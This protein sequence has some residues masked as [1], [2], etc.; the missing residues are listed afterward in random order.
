MSRPCTNCSSSLVELVA[1]SV[2]V[3]GRVVAMVV[4][5]AVAMVVATA[6]VSAVWTVA[7]CWEAVGWV[8]AGRVVA[9]VV[10]T[11][12]AMVVGTGADARVVAGLVVD[13]LV[14]EEKAAA[15]VA[16]LATAMVE[17]K[18]VGDHST[19]DSRSQW[20]HSARTLLNSV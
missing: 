15:T 1:D 14:A 16:V 12:V 7:A 2:A 10:A 4:V 5:M 6:A 13:A 9:L 8:V 17:K 19:H 20:M 3:V 18:V 11:V